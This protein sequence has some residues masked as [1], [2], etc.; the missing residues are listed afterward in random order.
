MDLNKLYKNDKFYSIAY[1]INEYE[2]LGC[3]IP[4]TNKNY[5]IKAI[6]RLELIKKELSKINNHK[7][8]NPK[9]VSQII[10]NI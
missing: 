3:F 5:I 7:I 10:E 9:F 2:H 4:I 1:V 8:Q 6:D